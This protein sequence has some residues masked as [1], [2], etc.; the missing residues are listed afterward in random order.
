MTDEEL[1]NLYQETFEG[2]S[3]AECDKCGKYY[4]IESDGDYECNEDDCDGRVCSEL[5]KFGLI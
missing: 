1:F 2:V 5:V 3:D 4:R